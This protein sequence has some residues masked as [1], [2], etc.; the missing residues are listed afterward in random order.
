[1]TKYSWI[2]CLLL[3]VGVVV[4]AIGA[5]ML[6]SPATFHASS[7]IVLGDNVSLLNEMRAM[8]GGLLGAG[9]FM[10]AG[11][12][13]DHLR[14]TALVLAGLLNLSFGLGRVFALSVDGLPSAILLGATGFEIVV[15]LV[16]VAALWAHRRP[17]AQFA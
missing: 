9:L 17:I 11:A 3:F 12:V 6:A 14:F 2:T 8:G 4:T 15:G 1:M 7:G 10:L 5:A 16:C 13:F